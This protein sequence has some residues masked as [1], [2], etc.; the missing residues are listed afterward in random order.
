[1]TFRELIENALR[2]EIRKQLEAANASEEEIASILR[3]FNESATF[4][5]DTRVGDTDLN[6]IEGTVADY[7]ITERDAY[8]DLC[9]FRDSI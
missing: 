9:E 7:L 6:T 3:G 2:T 8:R 5:L 1:M 4:H